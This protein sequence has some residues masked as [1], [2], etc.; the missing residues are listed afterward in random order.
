MKLDQIV[1]NETDKNTTK[2]EDSKTNGWVAFLGIIG[3]L[4]II[5]ALI[6]GFSLGSESYKS[7]GFILIIYGLSGGILSFLLSFLIR[8]LL[9]CRNYLKQIAEK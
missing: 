8:I 6:G 2:R 1:E 4:N 9:D 5:L 7:V 3:W